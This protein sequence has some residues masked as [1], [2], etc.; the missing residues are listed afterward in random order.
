MTSHFCT[1]RRRLSLRGL[2]LA[3]P[4]MLAA[5][6]VL[7]QTSST[8]ASAAI[9][10]DQVGYASGA[11]KLAFV[12]VPAK[13]FEIRRTADS[14][15]VFT[16]TLS[17]PVADSDTGDTLQVADFSA[18][19]A[20]GD[21]VL[22]V[23][24]VGRSWKFSIR[25]DVYE[26]AYTLA[27]RAF[28][29]QRCG[30][31][32]DMGS[33]FPSFKHPACHLKS[34]FHASSGKSGEAEIPGGWHDA[35]DYGR[36]T[37][38]TAISAG[39]LLNTWQLYGKKTGKVE[40]NLPEKG[41]KTPEL[42]SEARWGVEWMLKMQDT[43]GGAWHKQT[44]LHF[45]SFIPPQDDKD[46]PYVIGSGHSPYKTTCASADVAA[47]AALSARLFAPYDK[48]FSDRS[49]AAA[50]KG[51]DW[52]Q[53]HPKE[54]FSNVP[55]VQ[56]GDYPDNDCSDEM[57]WAAA[58]LWQ[59]TG[60]AYYNRYFV[61]HYE[62]FLDTLEA[63]E[64][65][66]W[67]VVAPQALWSYALAPRTGSDAPAVAA[68]RKRT[69][70]EAQKIAVRTEANP[71]K[72]SLRSSDYHWGSNGLV[73]SY[74][75]ELLIADR[76]SPNPLFR[77]AAAD[78]LHYLLGRNTFSLSFVTKLGENALQHP[79]HRPSGSGK[80]DG[81]WPGLLSGGP[82]SYET[83]PALKVLKEKNPNLPPAKVFLDSEGSW[84]SNEIAINWQAPLVFLLAGQLP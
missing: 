57:L 65:E 30:V 28:Y 76:F 47:V 14:S 2:F 60:D 29:G 78:D 39:T 37:V 3:L 73:A 74:G 81:A 66:N 24:G 67:R 49:L 6:L 38:N 18:L 1:L 71:Y 8:A 72:V 11:A 84:C 79:H 41:Q 53:Q 48:D 51:F 25:Q 83:D 44:A 22:V 26:H 20:P 15:A 35:G 10:L 40:L 43:D 58:E 63:P 42:L 4:L 50:K 82:N 7:A 33:E 21:Y 16:G 55:G 27:T 9:K 62:K 19:K 70:A 56:S 31:E 12:A 69:V 54:T 13:S 64:P 46:L 45:G 36:Y 77:R 17:A 32:V 68:I 52:A 5:P 61:S 59:A 34:E 75:E 80:Y 23:P